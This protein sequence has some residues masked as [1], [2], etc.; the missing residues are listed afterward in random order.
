MAA[1]ENLRPGKSA[2]RFMD[3]SKY[4]GFDLFNEEQ[5]E[6]KIGEPIGAL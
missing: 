4:Y 3:P 6:P 5:E 1:I 2:I